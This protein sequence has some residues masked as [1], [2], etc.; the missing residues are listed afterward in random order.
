MIAILESSS[1]VG[2]A[3]ALR[4]ARKQFAKLRPDLY[5]NLAHT[6]SSDLPAGQ[7]S[8]LLSV[9]AEAADARGTAVGAALLEVVERI[10]GGDPLSVAIAPLAPAADTM[11]IAAYEQRSA[12][13][14]MF[15][16]LARVALA[17]QELERKLPVLLK[18]ALYLLV[19][20]A[21]LAM[22]ALL[23]LPI[24]KDIGKVETWPIYARVFAYLSEGIANYAL[25]LTIGTLLLV[26]VYRW[27]LPNW[28]GAVRTVLDRTWPYAWYRDLRAADLLS[29]LAAQLDGGTKI[30]PALVALRDRAA[31]YLAYWIEA[32]EQRLTADPSNPLAALRVP[33]FADETVDAIEMLKRGRSEPGPIINQAG[34]DAFDTAIRRIE[35][36]AASA[37]T[38]FMLITAAMV[39]WAFVSMF[40]PIIDTVSKVQHAGRHSVTAPR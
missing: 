8:A 33:L 9:P 24:M 18:P 14:P 21:L 28:T 11:T 17:Q 20:V 1:S 39:V 10:R 7:L 36:M 37:G 19:I 25:P 12:L 4:K 22:F 15:S 29:G 32:I 34:L 26:V 35:R 31:P 30:Q 16:R 13:G 38:V 27:S 6:Y 40:V 2:S 3:I 23:L 5:R